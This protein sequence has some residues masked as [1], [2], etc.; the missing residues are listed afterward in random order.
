MKSDDMYNTLL[1]QGQHIASIASSDAK[2][3][4]N[5]VLSVMQYS[6]ENYQKKTGVELKEAASNYLG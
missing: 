5:K 6:R 4:Y 3:S 2:K 1:V